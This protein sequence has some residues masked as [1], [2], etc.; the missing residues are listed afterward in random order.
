MKI[1]NEDIKQTNICSGNPAH[2]PSLVDFAN[3]ITKK[4]SLLIRGHV[5]L[6]SGPVNITNLKEGMQAWLKDHQIAGYYNFVQ[7]Q[8]LSGG[9]LEQ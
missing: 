7:N 9:R 1:S 2:R 8:S 5:S 6:E 4:L 3:V